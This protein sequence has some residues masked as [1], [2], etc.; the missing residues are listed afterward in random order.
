MG[1]RPESGA[2]QDRPGTNQAPGHELDPS[3]RQGR[4]DLTPPDRELSRRQGDV[5]SSQREQLRPGTREYNQVATEIRHSAERLPPPEQAQ[6][7]GAERLRQSLGEFARAVQRG[8]NVFSDLVHADPSRAGR[9]LDRAIAAAAVVRSSEHRVDLRRRDAPAI[10][11]D[12]GGGRRPTDYERRG[13][14]AA[15]MAGGLGAYGR[16]SFELLVAGG[17]NPHDAFNEARR[18]AWIDNLITNLPSGP[19]ARELGRSRPYRA[20]GPR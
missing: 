1:W 18:V 6:G 16:L 9:W 2:P 13:Q 19:S 10:S 8:P 3:R 12:R 4:Q 7:F 11:M 15:D 14:T 5:Q 17:A 20:G